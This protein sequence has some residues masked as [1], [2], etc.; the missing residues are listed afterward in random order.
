MFKK[1]DFKSYPYLEKS[2]INLVSKLL[3]KKKLSNFV[4]SKIENNIN[5]LLIKKSNNLENYKADF[6]FL[7]GYYVRK[8][9]S[10]WSNKINCKFSVSVNSATTAIT[11]ALLAADIQPGDEVIT[12]AYTFTA[13]VGAILGANGVPVFCDI[14]PK[15]MCID[16][17]SLEK[18]ISKHT[19]F[20]VPVHWG[21]NAGELI[22]IM[23]IA[24]KYKLKIIEDASHA[25]GNSY[26]NKKIGNFGIASVFSF[27]Q[28]KNL[29]TGEGGMVCTNNSIIA[30]KSRLIRNHGEA[31]ISLKDTKNMMQNS[32]GYNYRLTEIQAAIGCEQI[33]FMDKLNNIRKKNYDFLTSNIIR[34]FSHILEPQKILNNEHYSYISIFLYKGKNIS[35]KKF[36]LEINKLGIPFGPGISRLMYQHPNLIKNICYGKKGFPWVHRKI[37]YK[38]DRKILTNTEYVFKNYICLFN[39]GWPLNIKKMNIILK[40]LKIIDEKFFK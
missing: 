11:V 17:S 36:I 20:I 13:T 7:G 3:R 16:P 14:D 24:K 35:R 12:T 34:K 6:S 23:K 33:R 21:G 18:K 40:G 32:V 27:N 22:K 26:H 25:P 19:K 4:G 38:N 2:S 31:I 37:N 30:K 28:P 29:M 5:K 9:E 1:F 39:M 8:F 15:T 10:D